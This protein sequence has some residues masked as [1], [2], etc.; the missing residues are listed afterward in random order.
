MEAIF[1]TT[2]ENVSVLVYNPLGTLNRPQK[3]SCLF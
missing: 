3:I 2:L 1:I